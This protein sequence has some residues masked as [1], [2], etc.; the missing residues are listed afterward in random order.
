MTASQDGVKMD[1]IAKMDMGHG[2][3]D[4][5]DKRQVVELFELVKNYKI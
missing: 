3:V 2:V 5:T 1:I 4:F